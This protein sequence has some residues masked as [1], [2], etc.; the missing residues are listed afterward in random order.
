MRPLRHAALALRRAAETTEYTRPRGVPVQEKLQDVVQAPA[1][2]WV[3]ETEE[4]T[5][6]AR[7]DVAG[8]D[9]FMPV[10]NVLHQALTGEGDEKI[11]KKI[12]KMPGYDNARSLALR[13]VNR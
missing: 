3:E 10:V 4:T 6:P 2:A 1:E 8:D 12:E 13:D 7:G 9:V 5:E 11:L